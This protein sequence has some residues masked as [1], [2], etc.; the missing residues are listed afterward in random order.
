MTSTKQNQC[1]WKSIE[2]GFDALTDCCLIFKPEQ[3]NK[4]K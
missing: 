1:W 4:D 3:K 2:N